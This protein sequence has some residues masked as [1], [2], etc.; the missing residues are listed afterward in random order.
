MLGRVPAAVG[1][2]VV[3]DGLNALDCVLI[4]LS[5]GELV[6]VVPLLKPQGN[7]CRKGNMPF[8]PVKCENP[9]YTII[10]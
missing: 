5:L 7:S 9:G 1:D 6:V 3:V 2:E 8:S 10:A 4:Q